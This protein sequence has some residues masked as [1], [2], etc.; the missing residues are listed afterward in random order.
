MKIEQ[1]L[2]QPHGQK[3]GGF[4]LSIK[5]F[6]KTWEAEGFHW[7]QVICMDSTGEIPVDV[8][9]GKKY[10][11]LRGRTREFHVVVAEIQPAEYLAKDRNKLIVHEW[12]LPPGITFDEAM[13]E[14]DIAYQGEIKTIRSKIKCLLACH[15]GPKNDPPALMLYLKDECLTHCVDEIMEG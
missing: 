10:N 5:T 11:P 6:K 7:Q 1:L 15:N 3:I 14:A 9:I 2:L 4:E 13:T 8:N 12:K